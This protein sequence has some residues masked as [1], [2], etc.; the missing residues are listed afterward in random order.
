[1]TTERITDEITTDLTNHLTTGGTGSSGSSSGGGTT[2]INAGINVDDPRAGTPIPMTAAQRG[3][4]YAQQLDPDVPMS[5]AAFAE[6]R[7]AVDAEIMDRAVVATAAETESGLLRVV[8]DESGEPLTLVDH[9]R[10]VILGERD[11]SDADDPRAAALAWIDEHRSRPT[12]LGTDALLQTFLLHLGPRHVIWYCWGH[13]LA[14]DGY[15]AMYMMLR[16]AQHYTAL[17]AGT[18]TP[19]ADI[20]S[21]AQIAA[22]DHEY[23]SSSTFTADR[24]HWRA[25]LLAADGTAPEIT[26]LAPRSDVASPTAMVHSATLDDALVT[27]IREAA[28]R[29]GVRTASV[30]TAAVALYLARINDRDGAMLS[31]PVAARDRDILRTSAGLTSNVVPILVDINDDDGPRSATRF[32]KATNADIK[33]AVRHQKYRHEDITGAVLSA[34]GGRR[35][36]F[37]PMV[38]VM[39]FFEHI[40]FGSLRGELN[41]LSTGPV[42]DASINVYDGFTGGM[43]MDVEANPNVYDHSEIEMHHERLIAVLDRFVDA[44]HNTDADT[45]TDADPDA[46]SDPDDATRT[47]VDT[48]VTRIAIMPPR[49]V[50]ELER[51]SR[52]EVHDTGEET[53]LDLLRAAADEHGPQT[54]IVDA[55]GESLTHAEFAA[56]ADAVAAGL[57]T[58]GIGP[59]SIVGVAL[60]RS[61]DQL[62]VL[63]G[64]IRAGA[65]FLPINPD[66]PTER[67]R[68]IVDTARPELIVVDA[69]LEPASIPQV[70]LGDISDVSADD[71]PSTLMPAQP[72]PDQAAYVLFTS[73]STGKPKGV[74]I[75]HRA[76][77]NRLRW[78]QSRYAL[79]TGDR[80]LQK[81][82]ATFDVSVW[83]F[84]WPFISGAALVIPRADGHRDPWYLREV[85]DQQ[86]ITTLHF[87]PSMLAAFGAAH[88]NNA[89]S[90]DDAA[91]DDA[92][93]AV[94][95]LRSLRL[96]FTSGE[97]LTAAAVSAVRDLTDAP[98][99]NLYGPTEAAIDVTYFDDA[100]TDDPNVPIGQPVWN[101]DVYVLDH[102]LAQQPVG[103]IGELY[104]GGIQLA[105]GYASRADLTAGRFVAAADGRR[106]YRTGD[107]VRL[108]TDGVLEYLGRTDSQVKI[109]GQR[110]ELGEIEAALTRLRG[111]RAA[112]V[113][114][115][116]DIVADGPAVAAYVVGTDLDSR[117]LRTELAALL[118]EHMIPA[119]VVVLDDLPTTSNGKLDRRA[120]P[121]PAPVSTGRTHVAPSTPLETLVATTIG[122]VLGRDDI[123]MTDD[124]FAL[125][126]NSLS[127][128]RIAARLSRIT[129]HRLGLRAIF[130]AAS[131]ADIVVALRNLGADDTEAIITARTTTTGAGTTT[132]T[133]TPGTLA[134][135]T[136]IG[137]PRLSPAAT[138]LW[139]THRLDPDAA[140]T[141]NVPFT[142]RLVGDL[143]V[144]A[145]HAALIDVIARHEP[146]RTRVVEQNGMPHAD[147][148]DAASATIDLPVH[149]D[150]AP[151]SLTDF[152]S[153]PF[154][155]ENEI[156]MRAR[157]VRINSET[158]GTATDHRLTIVIHHIAA[159]GWSLAPLA[160]DLGI[161]YHARLDGHAP[162][163]A[164]LPTTY[165]QI[166][167]ER[168]RLLAAGDAAATDLAFWGETLAHL[169]VEAEL[170]V[171]R[172]RPRQ[173]DPS[174]SSIHTVI[175]TNRHRRLV[176]IAEQHGT[177]VF[178]VLH[179][180]TA[181]LLRGLSRSSDIVI[182]T[183]VSG[184]GDADLDGLVGM[185]VNTVVLRTAVDKE[186]S[187][188]DLL[189]SV[190]ATDLA[191]F[192]HAD[193]P[194]DHVVTEL[195]PDRTGSAHPLFQVSL[196][197]ED[198]SAITLEFSGLAATAAR[199]DTGQT[200]FDLQFT[201]TRH[202]DADGATGGLGL[203]IG[204][205]SAL[206]DRATISGIATR[207]K[208]LVDAVCADDTVVIGDI[209]LLD[210]QERLD[211]LP[212]VGPGRRPV[213]HLT[214]LLSTAAT[215]QPDRVAID[216]GTRSLTYAQ[217]DAASNSLARLLISRGIGA[218]EFV[219]VALPRGIDWMVTLWAIVRTGAAWVPVDPEYPAARIEF[220]IA[221]SGAR[222]MITD[223][224][225]DPGVPGIETLILDAAETGSALAT[226]DDAALCP[227]ELRTPPQ[228]D[229]P[230]YLIYTSGTTGRPKGVVV[231]H[232]GLA[233]FAAEQVIGFG[234]TPES[235][236]MQL[237][238]P[239]FD[240]SVLELLM[241]VSAAATMHIVPTGVVGGRDLAE[242]MADR[243]VTHA[244]LTPSLLTTMNP[245]DLPALRTLV[246]GGEHPNPEVVRRWS[247]GRRLVNAYGPTET[248]V[249]ATMSDDINPTDTA[250]TIGRPIRGIAAMVLDERLRPVAPGAVG[251]LY[252]A[253]PHLAR[254][255]HGVVPLTSKRFVANP[256]GE[257]GDRMYRTGDLVRW[258]AGRDLEFRGRADAQ[259]KIR[260]HRIELGEIDAALTADD[261]V[262]AAVTITVGESDTARLISYVAAADLDVDAA[263]LRERL[264]D[265]LPRHMIPAAIIPI[266]DIPRTPSGKVD[267][268]ALPAVDD[269]AGSI[270]YRAPVTGGQRALITIVAEQL[271]LDAER[272]G[273][274]HDFFD[275]GGNSLIATGLVGA[276]EQLGGTRLPVR[277]VFDHPTIGALARAA[278]LDTDDPS[279]AHDHPVAALHHDREHRV[280]EPGAAQQQL[281]FLNRLDQDAPADAA[282]SSAAPEAAAASEAGRYNI[283][284]ALDLYGELDVDALIGALRHVVERHEPLRTVYPDVDGRPQIHV[285]DTDDAVTNPTVVSIDEID[286]EAAA[287][288]F[289]RTGFDLTVDAP[290]RVM[291]HRIATSGD[292]APRHT[293]TVVVHHI[294]A[295]GWSMAP[296]AADIGGAYAHLRAGRSPA[297]VPLP[298]DY[299]D[300]LRWQAEYLGSPGATGSSEEGGQARSRRDDLTDWWRHELTDLDAAP[301][302]LPDAAPGTAPGAGS[303]TVG[304]PSELRQGLRDLADGNATEFMAVHAVLAALLHRFHSDP[305]V[306]V[307]G[308]A[309]DVVIGTPV[310]GRPDPRLS[311]LVGMF[312]NSVVLRTAVDGARGFG[313]LIDQVRR[314]DLEALSQAELP[315]EQVVAAV[316][317]PRTGRHPLFQIVLALDAGPAGSEALLTSGVELDGLDVRPTP[318]DTGASR[319]DL[320]VRL[321]GDEV[322]FTYATDVFSPARIEALA[323]A[324]VTMATAVVD[325]P[326]R[327]IDQHPLGHA[328]TMHSNTTHAAIAPAVITPATPARH[329]ADILAD[330]VAA[331]ADRPA[332]ESTATGEQLTYRELDH[333]SSAWAQ[334]LELLG[335]GVEDV[336]AVALDRSVASVIATWAV[337]KT[338]A[339]IMPIDSRYPLDRVEHMI[340]DS[341]P[342]VG[343]TSGAR[344]SELPRGIWWLDAD[345]LDTDSADT[346]VADDARV[347]TPRHLDAP[348]YIVYTSGSTG[349]P[350][351]VVVTHRGLAAF[352]AEQRRRYAIEPGARTLHFASPSFD[353]AML[354]FLAAFDTGA[355]M[356]I[357]DPDIYGG[358]ELIDLLA[359]YRVSHAFITPAALAS[360]SHRELP[361][362]V[363]LGVGGEASPPD[364]V[365][366]WAPGRRYLNCYGPT[367]TTIVATMSEPLTPGTPVTIGTPIE[368]CTALVLDH[369]CAPVPDHV[370]GELYLAGPG[371]ARGYLNRTALTATRF[372]AS[373]LGDGTLMYR[374]GDIVTRTAR[375]TLI[376]HGRRDNQVKVRGFRIELDE[377]SGAL[378][379][380]PRVDGAL[381][382]VH[383]SGAS[384][385]LISYVTL[386]DA[387][388]DETTTLPTAAELRTYV[389]AR[390]PRQM[391]PASVTVLDAIPLTRNGKI[392]RAALP[393]PSSEGHHG[394]H[395]GGH[396]GS[397][398]HGRANPAD[399]TELVAGI[400]A[401]VLGTPHADVIADDDFFTLGGTSLQATT[402][403][404]RING[405]LTT[406]RLRVRDVF[407]HPRIADL[408]DLVADAVDVS[409]ATPA[410]ST[411][412]TESTESTEPPQSTESTAPSTHTDTPAR[413]RMTPLAPVQRRLWS[414]ARS[415]PG[416]VEY[417]MPVALTLRGTLDRDALRGA[418]IDVVTRHTS[419]RTVFPLSTE[420][421]GAPS[422]PASTAGEP[423]AVILD[424]A[425]AVVGALEVQ[426]DDDPLHVAAQ[427]AAEPVDLTVDP[428]L[429]AALVRTPGTTDTPH[430]TDTPDTAVAPQQHTLILCIHHIAADGASLPVLVGDLITAYRE[431][432]AGRALDWS[433]AAVDYRDYAL[434]SADP[435]LHAADIDYWTAVLADS[436]A[437]TTVPASAG[438]TDAATTGGAITSMPIDDELRDGIVA[439]A[440]THGTTVFSTTHMALA[441]LLY[442]LGLGRDLVI[443]T[444]V[445]NR[446]PRTGSTVD[447]SGV[448]GMFVNTLA[449]RTRIDPAST[450][451]S[452]IA[453]TRNADLDALDHRDAPFD[454]VVSAVNPARELGRH[455]LFQIALSVHGFADGLSADDIAVDESLSLG[456]AEIPTDTAKF[457]LQ[458]TL[459]GMSA[460]AST[461]QVELSYATGRYTE[462]DA[463]ALLTRLLRVL[464]AMVCDP[465]R[466]VGD[467]RITEPLEVA[468]VSP[469]RGPRAAA[470]STFGELLAQAVRRNPVG[471]AAITDTESVTYL[472][473]DARSNRLA[474][475]LLGRGVGPTAERREPVVAMAIPRSIE[476]LVAIW[477]IIKTGA[478]YVPVD[479]TYPADRIAHMLSDSGAALVVTTRD[480]NAALPEGLPRIALD[481]AAVRTRLGHSS[482]AA[483]TDAERTPVRTD[484]LAYVIYTSGST[485]RP[486]GVLVPHSGLRA[487]RDELATRL[488]PQPTS[489]VLH[490]AS[491]SFDASVLEFLMA[492]AGSSTLVIAPPDLY[493]GPPLTE[494]VARHRVTHA[495]ITPAAVASMDPRQ[496]PDLYA[497]AVGGE[498][499]GTDLV[500]RW[501]PGRCMINVYGPTETTVI[502]TGSAQLIAGGDLTIGTPNNG[503]GILVLD[504]RLHPVPAGV[505]GELYLL[506]DQV[507]RGYHRRP[508]LTAQRFLPV[509]MVTGVAYAGRRMYRTGDLVRRTEDG[510][511]AYVGRSDN[512]VQVR[513]FRIELGEIDDALSAHPDVDFAV[514]VLD[515]TQSTVRAYITAAPGRA[516]DPI[517]V[518]RHAAQ[519]LP[520][521][522]VPASVTLIDAIPLTPVGKLDRAALPAPGAD[523]PGR[524]PA[525]GPETVVAEVF[526]EVLGL[527]PDAVGADDGFFDLGGNSLL[528]TK[529]TAALAERTGIEVAAQTLFATPTVAELAAALTSAGTDGDAPIMTSPAARGLDVVLPLRRP[530]PDGGTL[531]PV[532]VVHPA[533]GLSWSFASLLGHLE[534]NRPVYGLQ[535]PTL[536]G[537]TAPSSI[538]E[539]AARYIEI[540]RQIAPTGTCHLVGWSLGGLIA[541]EMAVQLAEGRRVDPAADPN[542]PRVGSLT[543]LDSYVVADRP[544]FDEQP[545]VA[546]LLREFGLDAPADREPTV[547]EAWESVRAAGGPIAGLSEA[548]FA[549]V[550]DVFRAATPLA[551]QW[552][553]RTYGGDMIFVSATGDTP[554]GGPAVQDW[555]RRITGR[556]TEIEVTCSHARMLQPENVSAYMDVAREAICGA[557]PAE[558]PMS[559][560][561][562][563][564]EEE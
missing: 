441:L 421:A 225:A 20:A 296:L 426:V 31:L 293:L 32:L 89:D 356:I 8:E 30:I 312:V 480:A 52:G 451:A 365:A 121:A 517:E 104:L 201:F 110:V 175:D 554:P 88:G 297:Q 101:T 228:V 367:E 194:F 141:Y 210:P 303:V 373:P 403:V 95:D 331:H 520:R 136:P 51:V 417:A 192:D 433:P 538:P 418:L 301:V 535:N 439:F 385:T 234:L 198:S 125:G 182:G 344:R 163:W 54:G 202:L 193:L 536:S 429:R 164:P 326:T 453:T 336:V 304:F 23:R 507:T 471:M 130:D 564:A 143:D 557:S 191:A 221:D 308:L 22:F 255:Y 254:G 509:P 377:V 87:V 50:T 288:V 220:M 204:Y 100:G 214:R 513:G 316:N 503:V 222:L 378:R 454:D 185:F 18:V 7:D 251:E 47:T 171:D 107:L 79:T 465:E 155:L 203:E 334:R 332:I 530:N 515:E 17:A 370:P 40:D 266:D 166:S 315:F 282:E 487:V 276:I 450:V 272:I 473:L 229:H 146:L 343:I 328:D 504:E 149:D 215:H 147:I 151:E 500:R 33:A 514:T 525:P 550:H 399:A 299:R 366:R 499:F 295:D 342:V 359:G 542:D 144:D 242:L 199:V 395:H 393:D 41:V 394:G 383:G 452:M 508:G 551:A 369:R 212:A 284:F 552:R 169:P 160:A 294:A 177:T 446:A 345:A 307:A 153:E 374:T 432:S 217:L 268:R 92:A 24:D 357:A 408:A 82:P 232:R 280:V 363:T 490:F 227:G 404:S 241:A 43:R 273:L 352:S 360:A 327:P 114:L 391:V 49:E 97:A 157:L 479:P 329:L 216:D 559:T 311:G 76:I 71:T 249:V 156:P 86:S 560:P 561:V 428:P 231:S 209:P 78:M 196:T 437:E 142:V 319:F 195:N 457:D 4:Y 264:A 534:P 129:G 69:R 35:G 122:T 340:A 11:F 184:R 6:F 291:L 324:F 176:E 39:L 481:D 19:P 362:L 42:E 310:A 235:R 111:V 132:D 65:A 77:V 277:A 543:L 339:A 128:T 497:L 472:E 170:P 112:G 25:R 537:G 361:D 28:G 148:I 306:H 371:L 477:A 189:T 364:L 323:A 131:V 442:R 401:D 274:D 281:W 468:E 61:V 474:R 438:L 124:F 70:T 392:D 376:Y 350:K 483:L 213:A 81:T 207:L 56:R 556:L 174:G 62:I 13:H 353:A 495:F 415:N 5:V 492:A 349:A 261:D 546:E 248:T 29:H 15:A 387:E 409:G 181:A 58:R 159:D 186:A 161:A 354:E 358:D 427:I 461:P 167:E 200:K 379:T 99:H 470:P 562:P 410:E 505:T 10:Q 26:S 134:P 435:A 260:G 152:A 325:D 119:A 506:G 187:F 424:D 414:L 440:R 137:R 382:L 102:R 496:V 458:F 553:P 180:A 275:L 460:G 190:R 317:P 3:I 494:F 250:L 109:R 258:T 549:A 444:P 84:F 309:S 253:G 59:E 1:M 380:H 85:I 449:L 524:R 540:I 66:E 443:G 400:I 529:V 188:A 389:A 431:R 456:L 246:I 105:R 544:G 455:P 165:S 298:V 2:D 501:A 247:A 386:D 539:L 179:A 522:M 108:R 133:T 510:R 38:N 53:L 412:S 113:V 168:H 384:A 463:T 223:S 197:V 118:P 278:G 521:H 523:A 548:D 123:S 73:G 245:D 238:S 519:A 211:L 290:M 178:M 45:D 60:A 218:E 237:A 150:D 348:A 469:A 9:Q 239:S 466:T 512:Q 64:V 205:A 448:V 257:A 314:T 462:A 445:A 405:T 489:R 117:H 330:A 289:A 402:V 318:V 103:A 396:R 528:A 262:R 485:G 368:Q 341:R 372:V 287:T 467:I 14:F 233:D 243:A 397:R 434:D 475:L 464:R 498:A 491:P 547:T 48:P 486:K 381:T 27:R 375:G 286:W 416:S 67:L 98:I 226:S 270:A 447:Y 347:T 115:R 83:E 527:T 322:T 244:F 355:T 80:V 425:A 422:I 313:D 139:L 305:D 46:D 252:I 172:P 292:T 488:A 269:T 240:A 430:T 138:R 511:L 127:A 34:P 265:R 285:L 346:R 563:N 555:R 420:T 493:G 140:A 423:V 411:Q 183:P 208:R 72:H 436:P 74:V 116:D 44:L 531:D 335:V 545:S 484:Q 93:A 459:T 526:G 398:E 478:A 337:A 279:G 206:F 256:F 94:A 388:P 390:L 224:A 219:A 271:G 120:L 91:V 516:P 106:L 321:R 541:Q 267:L 413:P 75:T 16:V 351:G 320:E 338:G 135:V 36:F 300:Y 126:G 158:A 57:V 90:A 533:I 145:L 96:I 502:T 482:P 68:H 154:D 55:H 173:V 263:M 518:R 12:D 333:R 230:A 283:A 476:A 532:F 406:P 259:T 162:G 236:T 37:G 21:M 558:A 63:H 407:D 419:L 302:L